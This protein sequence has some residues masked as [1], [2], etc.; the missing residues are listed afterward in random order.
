MRNGRIEKT[1][2]VVT[3]TLQVLKE[4]K[5][6]GFQYVSVQAFTNDRRIDYLEPSY[7]ELVPLKVLPDEINKI[8]IFEPIDSQ[9][10]TEWAS[11]PNQGIKVFVLRHGRG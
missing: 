9:M 6:K 2:A 3:L 7:L 4:L 10:L 5:E 1:G 8:G 11:A